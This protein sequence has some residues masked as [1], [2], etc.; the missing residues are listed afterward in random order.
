MSEVPDAQY[1]LTRAAL[2]EREELRKRWDAFWSEVVVNVGYVP[3]TI[4][5]CVR[6]LLLLLT[7]A[8]II[9]SLNSYG[10]LIQMPL[11]YRHRYQRYQP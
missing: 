7:N 11:S 8:V 1:A 6:S 10:H 2:A 4:H 3:L 5:W 9:L